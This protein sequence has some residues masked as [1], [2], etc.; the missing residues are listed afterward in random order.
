LHGEAYRG[1]IFWDELY[2]FPF[3]NIHFP[4]ITR[5][6]LMY[7]YRRLDAARR[8][9]AENG[10]KGAMFPWQSGSTGEEETQEIHLNPESGEWGPDYSR[11]QR[12]VSLAVAL[13]IIRYYQATDDKEFLKDYGFE[14]LTEI[15]RF[16][17]SACKYSA[18]DFRY[19]TENM[20]GPDEFHEKSKEQ[21]EKGG[22]RDNAYT[23]IMLSWLLRQT[24]N[25]YF[26]QNQLIKDS[27]LYPTVEEIETWST[28]S[29]NLAVKINED[30]VIE[31]FDGYFKLKELDW[32]AYKKKYGNIYRLDRILKAEGLN[33]DDYKLAK[34]ADTLM[35]FYNLSDKEINETFAGLGYNMP[36]D[37]KIKNFY[38]Y[39]S[40][41]SHGSS[42]SRVVH[43]FL[44]FNWDLK[45]VAY[46]LFKEA[47]LSDYTD[48]QGGTTAEGVHAGVMA[49]TLTYILT[50]YAGIDFRDKV[51]SISPD[52]P[53]FWHRCKFNFTFRNIHYKM[54]VNHDSFN[55][56]TDNDVGL[57]IF[58]S[59]CVIE[60]NE[61][62]N[63]DG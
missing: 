42:L 10:F 31:Q 54:I 5:S 7:R 57:R 21:G 18:R 44:A 32:V 30:G 60:K 23:N 26:K 9:A 56:K 12:H 43:A 38:Y 39:V 36:K 29:E 22:L 48:I 37:Y 27:N 34:Q 14:M 33:P 52:M 50:T 17:V 6:M 61:W 15:C 41:T 11:N 59:P 46:C 58:N 49:S 4:E 13:N 35:A 1:H 20:M 16:F 40:R 45:D 28:I 3:Y 25:I 62:W 19:H 55:L 2:I 53:A 24:Q 8:Y 47:L 63:I 51:L